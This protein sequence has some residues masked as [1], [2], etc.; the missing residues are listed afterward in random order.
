MR[1]NDY[2][3][4]AQNNYKKEVLVAIYEF[5][6]G[7]DDSGFG[8]CENKMRLIALV[9]RAFEDSGHAAVE[10]IRMIQENMV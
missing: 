10:A 8:I 4:F 7:P 6:G 9:D 1:Y 3:V 5:I 2:I